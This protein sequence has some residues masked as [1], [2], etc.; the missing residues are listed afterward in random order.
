[1]YLASQAN[2]PSEYLMLALYC[3]LAG[4]TFV[5]HGRM[6]VKTGQLN[7]YLHKYLRRPALGDTADS[8]GREAK[9]PSRLHKALGRCFI[10]L[11]CLFLFGAAINLLSA[12]FS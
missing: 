8:L 3:A 9:K 6:V 12:V 7:W 11:G 10:G 5:V 4:T 2:E 1:M